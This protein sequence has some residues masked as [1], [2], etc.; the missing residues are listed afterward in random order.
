MFK[1]PLIS[2]TF[3]YGISIMRNILITK[4]AFG[5]FS[6]KQ[7]QLN[8]IESD[9]CAG[10]ERAFSSELR[11]KLKLECFSAQIN[12]LTTQSRNIR[13]KCVFLPYLLQLLS[14]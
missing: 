4:I 10:F 6:A 5:K 14:E 12:E 8:W 7:K 3:S 2:S 13:I 11:V 9:S 1:L